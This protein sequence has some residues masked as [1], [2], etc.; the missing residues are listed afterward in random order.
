MHKGVQLYTIRDYIGDEE[1]LRTSLLNIKNMGYDCV[2]MRTPTFM[3][4]KEVKSFIDS[5]GL[6]SLSVSANFEDLLADPAALIAAVAEAKVYKTDL[7]A[8]GTMPESYRDSEAG[9][10]RYAADANKVALELYKEGCKLLYHPHALEFFSLGSGTHGMDILFSET[11]PQCVCFS[12]DTHWLAS[13][14]VNPVEWIYK[15]KGRMPLVHFKDYAIG[16]G[17]ATIE[18]VVKLFA[19]VGEGNLD[20]PNIVAA[21]KK[22]GVQYVIVEQDYCKG[23]PFD[24][25]K[26]S[27]QNM[28]K[29]NV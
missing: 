7:V 1:Q 10:H 8:V 29:F 4:A 5:I 3:Q 28:L 24:S 17:A 26:I 2:Q 13:G 11:N 15:A 14:G 21:C 16:P 6:K 18:T 20:W 9:F 27:Y 12:L 25:L 19:E 23:N 22:I